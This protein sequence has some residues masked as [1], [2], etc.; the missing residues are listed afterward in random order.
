MESG[1]FR[2]APFDAVTGNALAAMFDTRLR[3]GNP[4]VAG[5]TAKAGLLGL[6]A[7]LDG[8]LGAKG[9][10]YIATGRYSAVG[11]LSKLG[12]NFGNESIGYQDAG[13]TVNYAHSKGYVKVYGIAGSSYTTF[14]RSR[15]ALTVKDLTD[16]RYSSRTAITGYNS[17]T[18]LKNNLYWRSAAA[19]SGREV[20]RVESRA[21]EAFATG[22]EELSQT[23]FST[24]NYLGFR[25]G[26]RMQVKAGSYVN[27]FTG[28]M[29]DAD[30]AS[31]FRHAQVQW[32]LQP[33]V[34]VN[35]SV[36]PA[37][38]LVSGMQVLIDEL[39]RTK[40]WLPSVRV[41]WNRGIHEINLACSRSAQIQPFTLLVTAP[42]PPT[43][44]THLEAAYSR[45]LTG[46]RFTNTLY[47]SWYSRIPTAENFS[48]F[49]YINESHP[50]LN[51]SE[52]K[53]RTYGWEISLARRAGTFQARAST[54]WFRSQYS[55]GEHY[56]RSRFDNQFNL[57]LIGGKEWKV[58]RPGRTFD[59]N[60]RALARDGFFEPTDNS[61]DLS[62]AVQIPFYAR[63]DLK[64]A[65]IVRSVRLVHVWALDVQNLTSRDNVAGYYFD[66]VTQQVETRYQLG[67]VP[68]LSYRVCF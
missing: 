5:G 18:S 66:P 56:Q 64:L 49:N 8:P 46:L 24:L 60:I 4:T 22:Y 7:S 26:Q 35:W 19:W 40:S 31:L 21:G 28:Y 13:V 58:N 67:I 10:S 17:V 52:G 25:A 3:I 42:L 43:V 34:S 38:D 62:R 48:A 12:V 55:F 63:L 20:M 2:I 39:S 50:S 54:A 14:D 15:P 27:R 30:S 65:Y 41:R 59:L 61:A 16:S 47:A 32:L 36:S 57:V 29:L 33:F 9:L 68:V 45:P 23:K 37:L 44:A 11:L 6:E 1:G 53:A 51:S